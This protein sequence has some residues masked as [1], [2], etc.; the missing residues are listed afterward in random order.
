MNNSRADM[1]MDHSYLQN[2][3]AMEEQNKNYKIELDRLQAS[4]ED[5]A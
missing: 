3:D 4:K 1:S 5:E 2:I